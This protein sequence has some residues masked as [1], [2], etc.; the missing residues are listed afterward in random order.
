MNDIFLEKKKS[1]KKTDLL[2]QK[3]QEYQ[4]LVVDVDC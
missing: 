2:G 3:V 4:L 1:K